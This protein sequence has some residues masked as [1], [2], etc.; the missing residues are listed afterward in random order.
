[1]QE[2]APANKKVERGV[3]TRQQLVEAATR[4]FADR[5]FDATSIE[6][7]LAETGVSRGALYHHFTSKE[8]LFEAVLESMEAQIAEKL[9]AEAAAH[10][11]PVESFIAGCEAWLRLARDPVVRRISLIDAPAV[12]GWK[13]WREID[14]AN[15][16]GLLKAGL[17]AIAAAGRLPQDLVDPFAH[18]LLAALI[19]IALVAARADEDDEAALAAAHQALHEL[20]GRLLKTETKETK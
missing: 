17:G 11:D 12:V 2:G 9:L 14:E 3:A 20:L 4:L 18:M 7:V 13:R 1:M 5:G 15:S 6:T 16:F 19:E 8:A 10:P